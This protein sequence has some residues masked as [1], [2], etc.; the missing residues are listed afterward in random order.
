MIFSANKGKIEASSII[1]H[2][3]TVSRRIEKLA[4]EQ[5]NGKGKR[6]IEILQNCGGSLSADYGKR[7]K[8]YASIILHFIYNSKKYSFNFAIQKC[9]PMKKTHTQV[10]YILH[11]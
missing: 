6:I 9:E 2:H 7:I 10:Y 11:T 3:T 8:D 4:N 1:P 5:I